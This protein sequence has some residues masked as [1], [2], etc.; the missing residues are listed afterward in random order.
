[1]KMYDSAQFYFQ[2]LYEQASD[3]ENRL[4]GLRGLV[5]SYYQQ[6]S[7]EHAKEKADELLKSKGVSADD[8]II[9]WMVLAKSQQSEGHFDSAVLTYKNII[10]VSKSF[11][12]GEA[13][14]ESASCY[15]QQKK[16]KLS[17][18]LAM[19]VI[20]ETGSYDVWVTKA[21][22]L[23]GDIFMEQRDYFNAKATY[24]SISKNATDPVIKEEAQRK[25]NDAVLMESRNGKLKN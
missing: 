4:E 16:F 18:K 8:K 2:T 19:S 6:G 10:L 9:S 11:W 24:E 23:L 1:M 21:Y 14:Y 7:Y 12:G 25:Y 5:R 13:R 15:F 20:N 17:E 22:L 3:N